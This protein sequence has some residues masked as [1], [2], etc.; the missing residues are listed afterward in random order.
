ML[1]NK[2]IMDELK[3][4]GIDEYSLS[5]FRKARKA[6][7]MDEAISIVTGKKPRVV[8]PDQADYEAY[9]QAIASARYWASLSAEV[10]EEI[11]AEAVADAIDCDGERAEYDA[12]VT[13]Y[14]DIAEKHLAGARRWA[15]PATIDFPTWLRRKGE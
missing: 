15:R 6:V 3:K 7:T 1:D 8:D 9:N 4:R 10:G 12:K 14:L 5:N 13:E 2:Q 11:S